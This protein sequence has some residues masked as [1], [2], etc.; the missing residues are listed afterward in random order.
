MTLNIRW[1][2]NNSR[3]NFDLNV[4][5]L[6]F[7]FYRKWTFSIECCSPG[8]IIHKLVKFQRNLA[9]FQNKQGWLKSECGKNEAKF[10]SFDPCKIMGWLGEIAE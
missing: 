8:L 10:R 9:P 1:K 2:S 3:P 6:P 5:N 4:S 7:G